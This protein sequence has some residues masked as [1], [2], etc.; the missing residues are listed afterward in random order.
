MP[1]ATCHGFVEWY[2][3]ADGAQS[4]THRFPV[5]APA[6]WVRTV[7]GGVG[8]P[9]VL[10]Q[11]ASGTYPTELL[12][13]NGSTGGPAR[14]VDVTLGGPIAVTL[15]QPA[16]VSVGTDHAI[17]LRSG[18]PTAAD[19]WHL[20]GI[21]TFCFPLCWPIC[22][23]QTALLAASPGWL[24]HPSAISNVHTLTPWTDTFANPGVPFEVTIQGGFMDAGNIA[25]ITN[26][27]VI[28]HQ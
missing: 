3:L 1:P 15:A 8:P 22:D 23:P 18:I 17:F 19:A 20:N 7:V 4:G 13:V 26:A 16:T 21:G 9:S 10:C 11:W 24:W 25:R 5:A 6:T 14:T 27:I 28:R 2:L 12:A